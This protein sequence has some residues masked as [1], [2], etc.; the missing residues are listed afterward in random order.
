MSHITLATFGSLAVAM[1]AQ[2]G[3][4]GFAADSQQV[5]VNGTT[6][7]VL[8]LY[9]RFDSTADVLLN[10]YNANFSVTGGFG[11]L[12]IAHNDLVG[13]SWA[14]QFTL[15]PLCDSVLTIGGSPGFANS[16][17]ADPSFGGAGFNQSGIPVGAGWFNGNPANLQGKAS[18]V[19]TQS[20]SSF[21][22]VLV[23][24]FVRADS[25]TSL[26]LLTMGASITYNQGLGTPG[27]QASGSGSFAFCVPSPGALAML[28]VAGLLPRWRRR[29]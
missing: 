11:P 25:S 5:S 3:F 28:V 4:I 20:G 22:G 23:G 16:T 26:K 13:G 21:I 10:V 24:R 15:V 2:A 9:A 17:Q 18:L 7:C 1:T 27:S 19:T 8:D 12:S 14:P 6:K 29:T